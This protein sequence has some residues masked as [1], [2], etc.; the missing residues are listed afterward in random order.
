MGGL[1]HYWRTRVNIIL[2]LGGYL[3]PAGRKGSTVQG[4]YF[5]LRLKQEK[6]DNIQYCAYKEKKKREFDT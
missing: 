4:M 2:Y 5:I 3:A 6:Y 1:V